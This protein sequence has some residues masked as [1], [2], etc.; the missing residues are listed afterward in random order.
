M[1]FIYQFLP[2]EF[3]LAI[4]WTIFHSLWQGVIISVV[5]G[6]TLLLSGKRSSVFR[7][8]L[9][10]GALA[11]LLFASIA[12]FS[13]LYQPVSELNNITTNGSLTSF[14]TFA[15]S[16]IQNLEKNPTAQ[17]ILGQIETIFSS[18]L[19]LIVTFWFFGLIIFSLRFVGGLLYIERLRTKN[20]LPLPQE[21]VNRTEL[22][23]KQLKIKPQ[24]K[25]YESIKV[26]VPIAVGYLKPVILLP[27]GVITGLPQNQV[28]AIIIHELAHIK[29]YDFLVNL[30]QTLVETIL[31]Y[32][33]AAWWISSIIRSEREDC[34]DDITLELCGDSLTYSK[35]LCNI[36]QLKTSGALF[37]LAAIGNKN[38]LFRRI[39][40]MNG[41]K[42]KLSYGIKFAAFSLVIIAI[43]AVTLYS[44]SSFA[45][46]NKIVAKA[47]FSD[48]F[49]YINDN[50][51]DLN[52]QMM[53]QDTTSIKKGKHTI[54]FYE[55]EGENR[56]RY[57]AKMNN[58][59]LEELY[60]NGEEIPDNELNQ[61][62]S[63]IQ[64]RVDEY[65]SLLNEY[66]NKKT[67]YK[68]LLKDY[69]EK[70]DDYRDRLRE[71][72]TES[73]S[74]HNDFD[75]DFDFDIPELD[76]SEL[77]ESMRELR[78][79]LRDEF[80]NGSFH[81]PPVPPIHIPPIH[82]PPIDI[83]PIP[84]IHFDDDEWNDWQDEFKANM[85][86]FREDMKDHKWDM[87]E[88]KENMK[89]FG[90]EMK[91]F[92]VEM[93]KFGEFMREAKDE[94][95]K[96]GIINDEDDIDQFILSEKKMEV[97]D[98]ELSPELHKKYLEMYEKHTGKKLEGSKK[99]VI[100]D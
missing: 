87:E 66:K 10:V 15:E 50:A 78:E 24:V 52:N 31:F 12:T 71:Y 42:N 29:R 77:R 90:E 9:S 82:I 55:G 19:P 97:N 39:K 54:K 51:V 59:K 11:L 21:L 70:L 61:Y 22:F 99:I 95:I 16:T 65:D 27:I 72:K 86:K 63:K 18:Y 67:E 69:S 48:P 40:R 46:K 85:E 98:K 26:K 84:P 49:I 79:E 64:K 6:V 94:L 43:V 73:H 44:P 45:S 62:E 36:Q 89:H 53:R 100:N 1:Y 35:A 32:H 76:M 93:K 28:E 5:L 47:G 34:C 91:V 60:V 88:F 14:T 13:K 7:Y 38:Q 58:G 92:G 68:E 25:I 17:N 83:P 75:H 30:L 96:D 8:N 56:K 4:G 80:A 37:A 2:R 74:W 33:P 57:K 3:I 81:V 20:I 23:I 41:N